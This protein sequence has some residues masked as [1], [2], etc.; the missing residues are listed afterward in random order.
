MLFT[1]HTTT[2]VLWTKTDI[3]DSPKSDRA[4]KICSEDLEEEEVVFPGRF[5]FSP[6]P[7]IKV[8][9]EK[10]REFKEDGNSFQDTPR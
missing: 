10:E 4:D 3:Q 6:S 2:K 8:A 5:C 7:K 9:D 1:V